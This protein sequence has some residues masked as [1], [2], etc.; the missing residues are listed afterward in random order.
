M[1]K[2]RDRLG[3]TITRT[4]VFSYRRNSQPKRFTVCD[5][6]SQQVFFALESFVF[7]GITQTSIANFFDLKRKQINFTRPSSFVAANRCHI[8]IN[9]GKPCPRRTQFG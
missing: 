4:T 1:T 7:V 6:I 2:S 8:R 3:Q 9:F 5:G